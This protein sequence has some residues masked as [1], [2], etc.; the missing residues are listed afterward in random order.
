MSKGELIFLAMG[1]SVLSILAVAMVLVFALIMH[2][3][4]RIGRYFVPLMLALCA[5]G[6]TLGVVLSG[7]DVRFAAFA[8]DSMN[9]EPGGATWPNRAVTFL[10]L[11]LSL[12]IMVGRIFDS[13]KMSGSRRIFGPEKPLAVVFIAYFVATNVIPAFMG[14]KPAF[15]HNQYYAFPL[16]LVAIISATKDLELVIEWAKMALHMI[17]VA[18]LIALAVAPNLA[19]QPGYS[20]WIPGLDVRLWGLGSNPNSIGPLAV[21]ALLLEYVQPTRIRS[22]RLAVVLSALVVVVL[23]QSK[24]AWIAA[25]IAAQ[26][27]LLYRFGL[28]RQGRL[29]VGTAIL[30]L[31]VGAAFSVAMMVAPP[32]VLLDMLS[33]SKAGNDVLT[34]TGRTRLWDVALDVW[35]DNPIFGFGPTLWDNAFRASIQMPFA[36]HAHNQFLNSM[37]LAGTVGLIALIAYLLVLSWGAVRVARITRGGSLALLILVWLRCITETPLN[38]TTLFNGDVYAHLVLVVLAARGFSEQPLKA[39]GAS[40]PTEQGP[41][42]NFTALGVAR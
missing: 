37:G 6:M 42:E 30:L 12:S 11:G 19:L 15:I 28:D 18:S 8:V 39:K 22:L 5:L 9:A 33:E 4:T 31:L 3:Q 21:L 7:R 17:M 27:I 34:L 10:I 13:L 38:I 23:A 26:C 16:F 20:G 29:R 24:T 1:G 25:T 2:T 32:T 35:M 36:M 41:S 40:R 14:E